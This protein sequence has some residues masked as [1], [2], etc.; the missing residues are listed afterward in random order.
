MVAR[1]D[2]F[3]NVMIS[4]SLATEMEPL[5]SETIIHMASDRSERPRP[6]VWRRPRPLYLPV[7][8]ERGR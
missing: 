3:G 1:A 6:A 5:S 8:C 4:S 7:L 2:A